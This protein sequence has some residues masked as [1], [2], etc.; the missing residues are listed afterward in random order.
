MNLVDIYL[1]DLPTQQNEIATRVR[2]L[3]FEIVPNIQE[4][5]SFK[6]PF[7]HYFGM[8][9]YI[10]KIPNGIDFC[11]CRGKDLMYEF[12]QLLI[13]NRA[14]IAGVELYSLKDIEAKEVKNIITTAAIW[15]EEAKKLK[16]PMINK[17]N[18]K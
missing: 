12:P 2:E 5:F 15:N 14:T 9:C 17:K 8:F 3:L 6:L 13:K 18:K 16:I 7:Y 10:N 1:D 4:K 11:I